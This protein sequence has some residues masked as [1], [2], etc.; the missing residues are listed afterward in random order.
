MA[1]GVLL[2]LLA[3]GIWFLFLRGGESPRNVQLPEPGQISGAPAAKDATV[4]AKPG[5]APVE[6]FKVFAPKDP[7]DPLVETKSAPAAD[8][9]KGG[10][11]RA[12]G[13]S[14]GSALGGHSVEL[15]EVIDTTTIRVSVDGTE[16]SV[17]LGE[18]FAD[19]FKVVTISPTCASLLYGDEQFTL[20]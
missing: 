13:G 20:C 17:G 18:T 6:T 9:L 10:G 1:W 12:P 5:K 4:S 8:G 3:T 15:V 14:Q 16:Y 19:S 2:G 7:F 11:P